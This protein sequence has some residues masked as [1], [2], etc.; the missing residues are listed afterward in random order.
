MSVPS[1]VVQAGAAVRFRN[2]TEIVEFFQTRVKTHFVDW[3]NA[4]CANREAWNGK[5]IGTTDEVKSR[6]QQIWNNIPAMFDSDSIN[7]LQFVAR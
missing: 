1:P 3:F 6:F 4:N 2:G 5:A 7:L